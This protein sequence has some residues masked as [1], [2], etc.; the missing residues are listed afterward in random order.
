VI[1]D[2][3]SA[4]WGS[5]ET[6]DS[7]HASNITI[8]WSIFSEPLYNGG[9]GK[10][11][12]AR[13][14]NLTYGGNLSVHHNLFASGLFRNPQ[15]SPALPE[16]T[17]YLINN[18][19][20]SPLWQYVIS[21]ATRYGELNAN[22]IGNYKVAGEKLIDDRLVHIFQYEGRKASLYLEGNIDQTYIPNSFLSQRFAISPETQVVMKEKPFPGPQISIDPAFLAFERVLET[23]GATRPVR[24]VV[25]QRIVFEV[26]NGLG[27]ILENDP[28]DVGG[29]PVLKSASYPKDIDNDGMPDKWE[30]EN[31]LDPKNWDDGRMD[32]NGN[33]WTNLEEYLHYLAK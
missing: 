22:V 21:L 27:N 15:I 32:S 24:D 1:L 18:V 12:R 13:N 29:W 23:A 26:R 8:Q 3:I 20:Y 5:D 17:I 7:E 31:G 2:H 4:S 30:L 10:Q 11:E 25:D 16:T 6:V 19:L 33:G 14:M 28:N 9:P